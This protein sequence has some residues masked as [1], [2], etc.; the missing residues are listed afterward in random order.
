MPGFA[1]TFNSVSQAASPRMD[2]KEL[3]SPRGYRVLR[4]REVETKQYGR[5]IVANVEVP[6][7]PR[8]DRRFDYDV[9]LPKRY[10]RVID[11]ARIE[12]Y[13]ANPNMR[14]KF[15]GLGSL[16]EHIIEMLPMEPVE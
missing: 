13:N 2:I 8:F 3:T 11:S 16:R 9:F 12:T 15:V 4:L 14:I 5:A 7:K 10:A 6:G 1:D